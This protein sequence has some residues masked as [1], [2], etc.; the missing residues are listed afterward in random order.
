MEPWILN[1]NSV[2]TTTTVALNVSANPAVEGQEINLTATVTAAG[3]G[4]PSGTVQFVATD[5]DDNT[6][7]LGTPIT[8]I[9]GVASADNLSFAAGSYTISAQFTPSAGSTFL[10]STGNLAAALQVDPLLSSG[11]SD[12]LQNAV[13]ESDTVTLDTTDSSQVATAID[14]INDLTPPANPVTLQVDLPA[15]TLVTDVINDLNVNVPQ[16][17]TLIIHGNGAT[18]VTGNS[19]ALTVTSGNVI[20][21]GIIFTT[22]TDAPTI[23]VAGGS[24]TLRDDTIEESTGFA[25]AAISVT[26]GAL[27]LGTTADPGGNTFN[28]NGAGQFVQNLTANAIPDVGNVFQVNGAS[29]A[30]SSLSFTALAVS[31]SAVSF[32]QAVHLTATIQ[33]DGAAA[34]PGGMVDFFDVTTNIDLGTVSLSGGAATLSI[35]RLPAGSNTITASYSGDASFVPG[36]A[37]SVVVISKAAPNV[38]V[39]DASGTYTGSGFA[40]TAAIT[41]INGVAGGSLEGTG[42][43]LSY[44]NGAFTTV[45]QLSGLTGSTAAPS[46]P[47]SYTVLASF[48]GSQD[49]TAATAL[50]SFTIIA[51]GQTIAGDVYVLN[52]T[53]SGALT[54]SGNASLVVAG[55]LQVDSNSASAV[56]LS[57][58]AE[59]TAA[60]ASIVGGYQPSGNAKFNHAPATHAA[61]LANP[62][63]VLAAPTGGANLGAVNLANGTLTIFPGSYTSITVSGNSHLILSP[64]IYSVGSGGI[65]ITGN[66][67]VTN[68]N[69]GGAGVLIYNTGALTVSGNASVNLTA[70]A[71]GIYA[72][73]A[74]FQAQTDASAV[75]ISGNANVNLN[76]GILYAAN[77][78]CVLT[79]SGNA[80]IAATLV[81]NELAISGNADDSAP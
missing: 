72:G 55:A 37:S 17:L 21:E 27:D 63:A 57:G 75:T 61:D 13:A 36:S 40:A 3:G 67:V 11:N 29:L 68:T 35:A 59:V 58:N 73:L 48:A 54:M 74:I 64:G 15:N 51:V 1:P 60:T 62:L 47:G 28:I 4:V 9:G 41:G 2:S 19:P 56:K 7:D 34:T 32:G 20:V 6:T 78:Q 70:A 65:T 81:V 69:V 22:A 71:A 23:L 50:T 5:S 12:N 79:I 46:T 24:L 49:Y 14:A 26:G 66:A 44:F 8:L 53:A 39:H 43:T 16:N 80:T 10:A 33:A 30:A 77:T 42:L 25:D 38:N 31:S 45:S 52:Q 18:Y 76:G